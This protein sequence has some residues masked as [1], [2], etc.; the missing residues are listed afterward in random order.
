M[1]N[2]FPLVGPLAPQVLFNGK[3]TGLSYYSRLQKCALLLMHS[4]KS[5]AH[6]LANQ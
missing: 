4:K 5:L 1:K 2:N 6:V 3:T